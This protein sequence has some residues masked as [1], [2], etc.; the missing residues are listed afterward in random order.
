MKAADDVTGL[1]RVRGVMLFVFLFHG[2]QETSGDSLDFW[3]HGEVR[4]RFAKVVLVQAEE[5]QIVPTW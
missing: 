1:V 3:D 4:L 5:K 2:G